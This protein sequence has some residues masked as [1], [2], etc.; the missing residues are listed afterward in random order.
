MF[1]QFDC[2]SSVQPTVESTVG[3]WWRAVLSAD[4]G[5]LAL[6]WL[7]CLI[8]AFLT[9][10]LTIADLALLSNYDRPME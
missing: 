5:L 7:R 10:P 6:V 3:N 8:N 4:A 1:T 9:G 2:Q